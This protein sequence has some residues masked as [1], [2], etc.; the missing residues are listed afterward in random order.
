MECHHCIARHIKVMWLV[1]LQVKVVQLGT[2]H[3]ILDTMC[4]H[5]FNLHF[6]YSGTCSDLVGHTYLIVKKSLITCLNLY[7]YVYPTAR[8]D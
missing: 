8:V 5:K 6:N 3:C 1:Y 4:H 2:I 7:M